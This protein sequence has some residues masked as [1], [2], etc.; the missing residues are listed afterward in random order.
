[1]SGGGIGGTGAPNLSTLYSG[2]HRPQPEGN[3]FDW[4]MGQVAAERD[5]PRAA[6]TRTEYPEPRQRGKVGPEV[7]DGP[8][9]TGPLSMRNS[10]LDRMP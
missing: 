5:R 2:P 7:P 6:V 10:P 3:R 4:I 1:M 9:F 8:K